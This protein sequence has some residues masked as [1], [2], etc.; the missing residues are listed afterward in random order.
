[1]HGRWEVTQR[2]DAQGALLGGAENQCL[3]EGDS[4]EWGILCKVTGVL[5]PWH[6]KPEV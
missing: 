6:E 1:M 4:L 2:E 3:E 5:M